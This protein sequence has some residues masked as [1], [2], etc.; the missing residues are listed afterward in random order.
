M[1]LA[2]FCCRK[3]PVAP[4]RALKLE[5]RDLSLE[6]RTT[7]L[8]G[9]CATLVRRDGRSTV[10]TAYHI[11]IGSNSGVQRTSAVAVASRDKYNVVA[12]A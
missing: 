9:S 11:R 3:A 5:Y 10:L 6:H 4:S 1:P 2:I 8:F 7:P 12:G